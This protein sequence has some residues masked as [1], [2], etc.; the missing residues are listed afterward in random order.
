MKKMGL[1]IWM[2]ALKLSKE[3]PPEEDKIYKDVVVSCKKIFELL[4]PLV[5]KE[6]EQDKIF[7]YYEFKV[8]RAEIQNIYE[9][10]FLIRRIK[11]IV[12]NNFEIKKKKRDDE[13]EDEEED[14]KNAIPKLS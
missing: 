11:D 13:D 12:Q 1:T 3:N 8:N 14:E 9:H 6:V 5:K 10:I 2:E 7:D 4:E